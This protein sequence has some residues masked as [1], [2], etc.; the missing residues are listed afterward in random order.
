HGSFEAHEPGYLH[1]DIKYLPQMVDESARR[2]LF[3][4]IDR[5]TRRVFVRLYPAQTAANARRFLRDLQRAAPMT[6]T[7]VLTDNG[8]AFTG[9]L[10]GLRRR[11]ASG[12]HEFDLLCA[13]PGIEHR[14]TPPMRPQTNGM[15]ERFNG[16]IGDVLRSH[17][18]HSGEDPDQTL[19]RYVHLY[20]SQLPQSALKGRTPIAGLKDWQRQ[21]PELFW[22][23]VHNHAGCDN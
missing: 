5:A 2:H 10:F 15:V 9:R 19:L 11:A 6:I 14:L 12:Q 20:N 13:E 4:A 1:V 17:R 16:R 21:R 22:K 3:V 23:R 18:F 7:R 8:K